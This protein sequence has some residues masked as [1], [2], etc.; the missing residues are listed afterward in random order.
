MNVFTVFAG[1]NQ[2][3]M[4]DVVLQGG[5]ETSSIPINMADFVFHVRA[6]FAF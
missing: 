3:G 4:G 6:E 2:F 5:G 1:L